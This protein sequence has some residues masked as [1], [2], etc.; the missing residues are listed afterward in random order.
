MTFGM[1]LLAVVW[2]VFVLRFL[3]RRLGS[4]RHGRIGVL[5]FAVAM[6]GGFVMPG[7][8]YGEI[9]DPAAM[10]AVSSVL[11]WTG[12]GLLIWAVVIWRRTRRALA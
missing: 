7:V 1:V 9:N 12:I 5:G 10:Q 11:F 6:V 4:T 3:Q 2:L 8:F